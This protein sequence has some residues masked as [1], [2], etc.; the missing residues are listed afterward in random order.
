[1][2]WFAQST[3]GNQHATIRIHGKII[4]LTIEKHLIWF[5]SGFKKNFIVLQVKVNSLRKIRMH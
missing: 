5:E 4:R 3:F 2:E 1:M